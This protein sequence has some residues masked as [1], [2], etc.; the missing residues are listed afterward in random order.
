MKFMPRASRC[1]ALSC[2]IPPNSRRARRLASCGGRPDWINFATCCSKWKHNSSSSS[3]S[4]FFRRKRERKRNNRSLN[5][6]LLSGLQDLRD[7][8]SKLAPGTFF[9][10]QL[11]VPKP[12]QLIKLGAAIVF[13]RAPAC[14]DPAFALQAMQRGIQG[15]LL[16]EKSL[17]GDL[18]NALRDGP[19][20]LRL[21][22]EG[23]EDQQVQ[24]ALR[25]VYSRVRHFAPL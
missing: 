11:L 1:S 5:M 20:V 24:G 7:R 16:Y 17:A 15:A 10:F 19:A 6:P 4:T 2:S 13:R 21:K 3:A 12:R 22:G 23:A 14:F 8:G 18:M 25:K 9:A